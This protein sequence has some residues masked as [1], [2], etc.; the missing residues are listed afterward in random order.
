[1]QKSTGLRSLRF[2]DTKRT[3]Y[4]VIQSEG[5][6]IGIVP[7]LSFSEFGPLVGRCA[8][9]IERRRCPPRTCVGHSTAMKE[10]ESRDVIFSL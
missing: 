10:I 4:V 7:T 3:D 2:P 1:M 6:M 8:K 9:N 5:K